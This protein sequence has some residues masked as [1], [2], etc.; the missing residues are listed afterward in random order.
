[1]LNGD[2]SSSFFNRS[3]SNSV[4]SSYSTFSSTLM[5]LI[6][7]VKVSYKSKLASSFIHIL[8]MQVAMLS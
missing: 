8:S 1:M 5:F 3:L 4:G 6:S 2:F 7:N